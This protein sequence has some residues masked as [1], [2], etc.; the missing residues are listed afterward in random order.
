MSRGISRWCTLLWWAGRPPSPTWPPSTQ[1]R[2]SRSSVGLPR[3]S[4]MGWSR[5]RT[6]AWG[7]STCPRAAA[8]ERPSSSPVMMILRAAAVSGTYCCRMCL[9]ATI[10]SDNAV[11][12]TVPARLEATCSACNLGTWVHEHAHFG[13]RVVPCGGLARAKSNVMPQPYFCFCSCLIVALCAS[14]IQVAQPCPSPL[15]PVRCPPSPKHLLAAL[16]SCCCRQCLALFIW[17]GS[18]LLLSDAVVTAT[19]IAWCRSLFRTPRQ[20]P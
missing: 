11:Q 5:G 12:S 18:V 7:T 3:C 19:S 9:C 1:P 6:P 17:Q 10:C 2:S 20:L 13:A 15:T 16:P 14:Y 4:C 8:V